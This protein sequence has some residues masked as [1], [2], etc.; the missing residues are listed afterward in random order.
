[1]AHDQETEEGTISLQI[2]KPTIAETQSN[3][4]AKNGSNLNPDSPSVPTAHAPEKKLTLFALRLAMLEKAATGLGTL[5][6]IW[7]TVVL[8]GGFAITLMRES[9]TWE[10][11]KKE[12]GKEEEEEGEKKKRKKIRGKLGENLIQGAETG[13]SEVP[14][15]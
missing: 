10:E 14:K 1:M 6:F 4:R 13:T 15:S 9:W 11:K 5:G 7:A 8:L 12:E 3:V 2:D